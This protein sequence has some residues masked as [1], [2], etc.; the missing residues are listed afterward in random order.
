MEDL[1]CSYGTGAGDVNKHLITFTMLKRE[2][3]DGIET[4]A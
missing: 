1:A 2:T 3:K 4:R